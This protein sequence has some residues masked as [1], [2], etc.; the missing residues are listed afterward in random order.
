MLTTRTVFLRLL[1][2]CVLLPQAF[3]FLNLFGNFIPHVII[4][5]RHTP[6]VSK[7]FELPGIKQVLCLVYLLCLLPPRS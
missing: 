2:D 3:G 6:G 7:L 5:A 1:L 4:V